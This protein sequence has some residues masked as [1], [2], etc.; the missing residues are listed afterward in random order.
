MLCSD[1][2]NKQISSF[3]PREKGTI[4]FSDFVWKIINFSLVVNRVDVLQLCKDPSPYYLQVPSS[5]IA[6]L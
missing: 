1:K 6:L 5:M 2:L 3:I 4:L